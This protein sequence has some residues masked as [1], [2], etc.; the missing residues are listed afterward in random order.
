MFLAEMRIPA[1]R[2]SLKSISYFGD[3]IAHRLRLSEAA[4]SELEIAIE[5]S[6]GSIIQRASLSGAEG[7]MLI[8]AELEGEILRLV[9][10][11]WFVF[12]MDERAVPDTL[13]EGLR[14]QLLQQLTESV[15]QRHLPTGENILTLLKRVVLGNY[16][17]ERFTPQRELIALQTIT[18]TMATNIKLDDLLK[19]IIEQLL[20]AIDC[21]RGTLY[22]LDAERGE[23]FSKILTE[24]ENL[25]TEIRVKVGEGIAGY[26]AATGETVNIVNAYADPRFNQAI[27]RQTGYVSRAILTAPMRNPESKIIGVVQVLNKR[28]GPF[29]ARDERM[30]IAIS[31]QAAI[32]IEN[33]RLHEQA[34]Q[35]E[36]INQELHVAKKIQMSLLPSFTPTHPNWEISVFWHAARR[37]AGDFYDFQ[38]LEDERWGIAI[39]DVSGKGIPAA[40]FMGVSATVLRFV[41]ALDLPPVEVMRNIN[42]ALTAM[43]RDSQM[44]A[45]IFLGFLNFE[46]GLMDCA[47]AGH[48]P[49]LVVRANGSAEYVKVPGVIAGMFEEAPFHPRQIM[50]NPGDVLVLYTDGITE[51][52]DPDDD[53]FGEERLKTLVVFSVD[54]SAQEIRDRVVKAISA[55]S[56]ARGSFDDETLIV[57]KRIR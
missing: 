14:L 28:G 53:L 38:R 17:R 19:L 56:G 51:A 26:V 24:D 13:Q 36:L 12:Q 22:L 10:T 48:N 57:I 33:A 23:L 20:A 1:V 27:D 30:L 4:R 52:T 47:A 54:E 42:K 34:L 16:P 45:S 29:S 25:L 40:L 11:D 8:R 41:T 2:E 35:Q 44:F 55:F 15:E 9:F 18:Q 50:V 46:T 7:D 31:A 43:N 49:P 32:S 39:G 5:E 37:V 6:V 21:E 3:G